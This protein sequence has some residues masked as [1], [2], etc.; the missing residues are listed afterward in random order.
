M[1]SFAHYE[2]AAA[3]YDVGFG[4]GLVHRIV[5]AGGDHNQGVAAVAMPDG[6]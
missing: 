1:D 5:E 6:R 4:Q 2:D 3:V